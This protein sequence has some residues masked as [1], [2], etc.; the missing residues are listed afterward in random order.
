MFEIDHVREKESRESTTATVTITTTAS[1]LS[2]LRIHSFPALACNC[3]PV[4]ITLVL[5]KLVYFDSDYGFRPAGSN[6]HQP[7]LKSTMSEKKN[8]VNQLQQQ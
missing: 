8:P 2:L 1:V 6:K 3:T 4:T 7:C 5:S